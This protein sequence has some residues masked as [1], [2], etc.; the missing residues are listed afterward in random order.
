MPFELR[1]LRYVVAAADYGSFRKAAMA[2][3]VQESAVSRRIRDLEDRM[4]ATLFVRHHSG[5]CLTYAGHQFVVRAR[6]AIDQLSCATRDVA[7][8]GRGEEGLVRIGI[9][10][11]LASG[12]LAQLVQT[13][14]T[15]HGSV[16]L[17][18]VEGG[19]DDHVPA[20]RQHRLDV[21]FLTRPSKADD[22]DVA[23]LWNERVF[24]AM[25]EGD[26]LAAKEE[27]AWDD[28]HGR[29]FV[30]SE[31]QPGPEIHD[32]L[33]KHLAD[34]GVSPEIE[35]QAVYRDTLMHIVAGGRKLTLT[36]EAT[37]AAQFPGVTYRPLSDETLPFCA[38]WSPMNDNPA[39]RRLLSLAKVMSK[40]S[41]ACMVK[42]GAPDPS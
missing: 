30:V 7:L 26:E 22:C 42:T 39:F 14:E 1:H 23:H 18:F 25:S 21:A 17:E 24:V 33:V 35:R 31:A 36:S 16:R 32:Y 13:Y 34:L 29:G 20:I 3:G 8:I 9:I 41:T 2:L 27:V 12:F 40:R 11:S 15:K 6:K 38:I 4:G 10:S 19:H 37:T 5:A 28:L